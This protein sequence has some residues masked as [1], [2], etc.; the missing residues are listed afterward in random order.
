MNADRDLTERFAKLRSEDANA[1]PP[2]ARTLARARARGDRRSGEATMGWRSWGF[3][4]AVLAGVVLVAWLAFPMSSPQDPS[5]DFSEFDLVALGTLRTATDS[6]LEF[7]GV[8]LLGAR[9]PELLPLPALPEKPPS[10]ESSA[11]QSAFS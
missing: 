1:A 9:A 3:V 10:R 11:R 4:S 8:R 2:A 7:R 6:L 5:A